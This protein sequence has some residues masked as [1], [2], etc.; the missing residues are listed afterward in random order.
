[1]QSTEVNRIER[2]KSIR[3]ESIVWN[4]VFFKIDLEDIDT[5]KI[6]MSQMIDS[7]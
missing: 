5:E 1:M 2:D 4:T 3:V 6:D 7:H